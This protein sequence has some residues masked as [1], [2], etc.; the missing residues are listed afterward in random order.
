MYI[1]GIGLSLSHLILHDIYTHKCVQPKK[2]RHYSECVLFSRGKQM[3][4]IPALRRLFFAVK[5]T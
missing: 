4:L 2:N 5:V 3:S 1:V